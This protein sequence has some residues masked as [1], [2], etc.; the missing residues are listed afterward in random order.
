[1]RI[2]FQREKAWWDAKATEED[3]ERGDEWVN[4]ALRWREIEGILHRGVESILTVGGG[5][6]HFSIPLARRGLRVT[7]LDI[8]GEMLRVAR[9]NA[10][11]LDNVTFV[12]GNATD[13]KQFPGRAFD[14]VL[15]MDGAVSF[16]GELYKQAISETCRVARKFV[17]I[18]ASHRALMCAVWAEGS[19]KTRGAI[20]DAVYEMFEN[21]TWHQ[22]QHDDNKALSKGCTQDYFGAFKAFLPRELAGLLE[23]EGMEVVK[24]RCL[25]TL[26]ALCDAGSLEAV[27][28]DDGLKAKFLDL[29]DAFDE[30]I[31]PGGFGTRNRAG[32]LAIGKPRT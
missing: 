18:T 19:V 28:Q 3:E 14:L 25:G 15:N 32:L 12:E 13:L 22:A 10:E 30:K 16:C 17:L 2:D 24:C 29:C 1:M 20:V 5:T 7:H 4:K 9:R 26:A 21:G 23:G 8:S 31:L 6:G 11:G 27:R